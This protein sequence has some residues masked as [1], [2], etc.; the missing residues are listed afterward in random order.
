MTKQNPHTIVRSRHITEKAMVLAGL[1]HSESNICT[2]RCKTP[3]AVFIVDPRASKRQI[4]A[5]VEEIYRENGV[6]VI[7]VNTVN[8]KRKRRRV[9][10]FLGFKPGYRKA[11]V[12][13]EAG[14]KIEAL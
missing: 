12:S 11:I 2:K 14:D 1:E 13:F 9:R 8:V 3:K 7:K 6:K 10:R 4:A 5:A